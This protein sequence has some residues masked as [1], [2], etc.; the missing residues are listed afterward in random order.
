M[1]G[2]PNKQVRASHGLVDLSPAALILFCFGQPAAI[3]R[4]LTSI[5]SLKCLLGSGR[6]RGG[7]GIRSGSFGRG[8]CR[9]FRRSAFDGRCDESLGLFLRDLAGGF[10]CDVH[11]EGVAL[12]DGRVE[13]GKDL[14]P[15]DQVIG[16]DLAADRS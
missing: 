12:K 5:A 15:A 14:R 1:Q 11:V 13:L 3:P 7:L 6:F 9:P 16:R 8:R 2:L 10:G 4:P